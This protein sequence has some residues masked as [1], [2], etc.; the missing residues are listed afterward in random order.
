MR[1]R[2]DIFNSHGLVK[3]LTYRLRPQRFHCCDMIEEHDGTY[4]YL[5]D[6]R[7]GGLETQREHICPK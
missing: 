2:L 5:I 7:A 1:Y 4:G 3:T 6:V